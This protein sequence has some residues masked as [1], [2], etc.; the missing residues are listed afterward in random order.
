VK[1]IQADQ[2][3]APGPPDPGSRMP[4]RCMR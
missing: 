2:G 4:R 1:A 3:Q